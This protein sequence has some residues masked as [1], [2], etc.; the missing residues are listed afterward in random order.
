[1]KYQK[2]TGV[3]KSIKFHTCPYE[4]RRRGQKNLT[5]I[6]VQVGKLK[7]LTEQESTSSILSLSSYLNHYKY[8]LDSFPWKMSSLPFILHHFLCDWKPASIHPFPHLLVTWASQLPALY[9]CT[10]VS[11]V[12]Q[13]I[14]Q[15]DTS[16]INIICISYILATIPFFM[17]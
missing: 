14:D 10:N 3:G 11:T 13:L 2:N 15:K 9:H 17:V 16:C 8:H 5:I 12:S 6:Q 4:T 1:M 7:G